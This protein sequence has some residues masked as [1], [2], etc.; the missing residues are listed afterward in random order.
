MYVTK[1]VLTAFCFSNSVINLHLAFIC[2]PNHFLAD[3]FKSRFFAVVPSTT[4]I[5]VATSYSAWNWT[6]FN[7]SPNY[8]KI[9]LI[10]NRELIRDRFRKRRKKSN[11]RFFNVSV[12]S[13][14]EFITR[15]IFYSF[16]RGVRRARRISR[17]LISG[18]SDA[19]RRFE[20]LLVCQRG[21][22]KNLCSVLFLTSGILKMS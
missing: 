5:T 9:Y 6:C 10:K 7:N 4:F 21:W 14:Y 13:K 3:I 17:D 12:V 22:R 20:L 19:V 16:A 2:P 15:H 8:V 18:L 11:W 1:D